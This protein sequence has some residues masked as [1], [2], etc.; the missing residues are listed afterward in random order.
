[1]TRPRLCTTRHLLAKGVLCGPNIFEGPLHGPT[2]A[3]FETTRLARR[4][5]ILWAQPRWQPS[6]NGPFE[7]LAPLAL[8]LATI[9][10]AGLVKLVAMRTFKDA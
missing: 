8:Q 7:Q 5:A 6:W 9:A 4:V 2:S 10:K 1:M 3:C